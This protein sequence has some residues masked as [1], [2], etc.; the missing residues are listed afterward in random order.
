M[1]LGSSWTRKKKITENENRTQKNE[2]QEKWNIR[3]L[4]PRERREKQNERNEER[5][6]GREGGREGEIER[7]RHTYRQTE[8]ERHT[9]TDRQR[10]KERE[11]EK[12]KERHTRTHA[13]T[14]AHTLTPTHHTDECSFFG[15]L[16]S[17]KS[18]KL[19]IQNKWLLDP[20]EHTTR[21]ETLSLF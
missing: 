9:Q 15:F 12:E 17:W 1:T 6:R 14:H 3:T 20:R 16:I 2:T 7:E 21:N 19:K 8:R 10:E 11:R 18:N 5:R 13:R 4:D